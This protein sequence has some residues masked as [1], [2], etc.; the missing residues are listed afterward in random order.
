MKWL[1]NLSINLRLFFAFLII[2]IIALVIGI[3]G[4]KSVDK[5]SDNSTLLYQNSVKP[6]SLL[7]DISAY[8]QRGRSIARDFLIIN[9]LPEVEKEIENFKS[10]LKT[11]EEAMD[12]YEK[13]IN[14]PEKRKAF[15]KLKEIHSK[16]VAGCEEF[17][18][19]ARANLDNEAF[20][21]LNG[22]FDNIVMDEVK[23]INEL[24]KIE[25]DYANNLEQESQEVNKSSSST[26]LTL[27]ILGVLLAL[28]LS[29]VFM[30]IIGGKV[31]W[32]EA[33][34]DSI[35]MPMSVT[36]MNMNW[37]FINK[38]VEDFLKVKRKDVIGK[39]CHNWG[40]AICKTENC[41][42]E[43]V[44]KNKPVTFFEQ[45]GGYFRVDTSFI[46]D[47]KGRKIGHVEFVQD[48]TELKKQS[49][50]IKKAANKI[51]EV[52]D[53]TYTTANELKNSTNVA[54]SSSE[55]I[56]ANA[57]SVSTAAEEMASSIK[58]ISHNTQNAS[59]ISK[60]ATLRS[61]EASEA[62]ERLAKSSNEV[63]S[64]IKIINNIAEQTNLLAL[65]A[66]IEAARAGEAGKGFA[67]VASE[68][69]T[70]AQESAKSTENIT[71]NIKQSLED[72]RKAME[73]IKLIADTIKEVN[74]ISNTIASAIE[75][76]SITVSEINRNLSE[77]SKGSNMISEVNNNISKA[78]LEYTT[79][80]EEVKA[81]AT[82][83]KELSNRLEA[84]LSAQ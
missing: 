77:V 57:S 43:R 60:E 70:L 66:T 62:M 38:A 49:E 29:Y 5:V 79:L 40:A 81:T 36:D 23:A 14:T 15:D 20:A 22:D 24:V 17:Y 69:K 4:L 7:I 46:Y 3:I 65:N 32:Y 72:T 61:Q 56:S 50:L 73:K 80:A 2:A 12:K 33:L 39:P 63:A 54:A 55:Q 13:L 1:K 11:Q 71:N 59:K 42:V 68:V 75:E 53:K 48:Q 31:A 10:K 44:R 8:F 76:Q 35:K 84:N 6:I 26:L 28:I 18:R 25:T 64:I 83:L 41:G 27:I 9:Y 51:L 34:L 74:D 19:L 47:N 30:K 16:Y 45:F 58:E 21:Y 52:S 82:E 37:T 78:A 67:V